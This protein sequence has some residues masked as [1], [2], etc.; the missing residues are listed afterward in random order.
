MLKR[1]ASSLSFKK[2]PEFSIQFNVS[3][4]PFAYIQNDK[5]IDVFISNL[6][7]NYSEPVSI[8]KPVLQ[9]LYILIKHVSCYCRM[10]EMR[11]E[12]VIYL[13]NAISDKQST[14]PT[15]LL[16]NIISK[17]VPDSERGLFL[18]RKFAL[19]R[20]QFF[21]DESLDF[22]LVVNT[23]LDILKNRDPVDCLCYLKDKNQRLQAEVKTG[24][25]NIYDFWFYP[26]SPSDIKI[27]I[28]EENKDK[29]KVSAAVY[30]MQ[31]FITPFDGKDLLNIEFFSHIIDL[32]DKETNKNT[33]VVESVKHKFDDEY[34][35]DLVSIVLN[36]LNDGYYNHQKKCTLVHEAAHAVVHFLCGEEIKSIEIDTGGCSGSVF[37]KSNTYTLAQN[38]YVDV[39]KNIICLYSGYLAEAEIS[40]QHSTSWIDSFCPEDI[41]H[42]TLIA[43]SYILETCCPFNPTFLDYDSLGVSRSFWLT[44]ETILLCD[45]L[46]RKTK[47]VVQRNKDM[48]IALSKQLSI[49]N[50]MSGDE[51]F[52]FLRDIDASKERSLLK[53]LEV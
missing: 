17:Y 45:K 24:E 22:N 36:S 50:H 51:V 16:S 23:C 12:S 11:I 4:N 49:F 7:R 38:G 30:A 10:S 48:I 1:I 47:D 32:C 33:D 18:K 43:K 31:P 41:S 52:Q 34:N 37:P 15:S 27:E 40:P 14:K 44:H 42:A 26:S 3:D 25:G 6:I 19:F 46:Y 13:L 2:K 28:I 21:F 39:A 29:R 5:D 53:D 9:L 8:S 35:N 20:D